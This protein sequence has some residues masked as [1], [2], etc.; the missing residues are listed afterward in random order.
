MSDLVELVSYHVGLSTHLA[1]FAKVKGRCFRPGRSSTSR[2]L[3]ARVRSSR[4]RRSPPRRIKPPSS[5]ETRTGT[6]VGSDRQQ[7]GLRPLEARASCSAALARGGDEEIL[8]R[9]AL[10]D[11]RLTWRKLQ[12]LR[13]T[14]LRQR[15]QF[16]PD[17]P[18]HF[19][20]R[21]ELP[22]FRATNIRAEPPKIHRSIILHALVIS[23]TR[24]FSRLC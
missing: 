23:F 15:L 24:A 6:I 2:V 5:T 10:P 19:A 16:A 7:A 1:E 20:I 13:M 11:R 12:V 17:G 4:S 9:F 3:R 8:S 22:P 14:T 18:L 21:F